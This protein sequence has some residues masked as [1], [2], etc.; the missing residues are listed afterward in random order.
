MSA[1]EAPSRR[2]VITGAGVVSCAGMGKQA[3]WEALRD[4]KSGVR[5]ITRFDVSDLRAQIAGEITD[6][7]PLD[8]IEAKKAAKQ[9]RFVH[10]ALAAAQMA[11]EDSDLNL[12]REDRLSIGVAFGT[13]GAGNGNIAD[14][15]YVRWVESEFQRVDPTGINEIPA[16]AASSHISIELGL[17]G[18]QYSLSTGCVTSVLTV[19]QAMET[20]RRGQATCMVAGGSEACLSR[21]IYHM[22]ARQRVLSTRNDDPKGACRPFDKDRDG[23]VLGEGAAAV[24]LE[25][26]EHA[27]KR[28]ARIYGELLGYGVNTEAYHMVIS[29]PTGDELARCL[30]DAMRMGKLAPNDIDY[31]CA[32]GI[33]NKEYDIGDTL[34]IKKALGQHAY[35]IPVTSIKPV[36]G[37]CFGA[38]AAMQLAAVCMV[39]Q[40]ETVPPTLNLVEPDEECDL[41][42]VP[43]AARRGRI[44]TVALNAHSFGGT[45]A[46]LIVRR[47]DERTTG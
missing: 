45:H 42:Y 24:V 38:G 33:G 43:G 35:H 9:G 8:W 20:I 1:I 15:H 32:H 47:F 46:A 29:I 16:H 31:F 7:D 6:F 18:P 19:G 13:S 26:A 30:R 12:E 27:M 5:R 11:L 22:L 10:F 21:P 4:G 25:S 39:L 40:T 28:G 41:D 3:F 14:D 34:G 17:K 44:D 23:L 2:V 37:Q 36:P